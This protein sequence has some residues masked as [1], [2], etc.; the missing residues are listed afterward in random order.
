MKVKFHPVQPLPTSQHI[1]NGL[2]LP[3]ECVQ[4]MKW[5]YRKQNKLEKCCWKK[6]GMVYGKVKYK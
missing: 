4:G 6:K 3:P 1:F 2:A 5:T